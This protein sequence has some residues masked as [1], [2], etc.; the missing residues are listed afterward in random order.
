MEVVRRRNVQRQ[1]DERGGIDSYGKRCFTDDFLRRL[2]ED[3]DKDVRHTHGQDRPKCAETQCGDKSVFQAGFYSV[4]P[5]RAEVDRHNRL[6]RLTDAISAALCER[7]KLYD[8]RIDGKLCRSQILHDLIIRKDR[9]DAHCNVDDKGRKACGEDAQAVFPKRKLF[10]EF[11]RILF[12]KEVAQKDE[13][14]DDR[15]DSRC[16]TCAHGPHVQGKD[17]KPIAEDIEHA[18]RKHGNRGKARP[19]V[20]ADKGRQHCGE[21]EYG[22]TEFQGE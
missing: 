17:E 10:A 18:A 2:H 22:Q 5:F 16:N 6:C 3:A 7:E 9:E 8:D 19:A 4:A 13:E 15:S 11:E 14:G 1:Q 12:G 21:R 20:V